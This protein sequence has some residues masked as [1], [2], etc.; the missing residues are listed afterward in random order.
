[1]YKLPQAATNVLIVVIIQSSSLVGDER[2]QLTNVNR[3]Y[4][5][6][7]FWREIFFFRQIWQRGDLV[8]SRPQINATLDVLTHGG[9]IAGKRILTHPETRRTA[10]EE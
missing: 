5:I 4:D 10:S 1:M 9:E 7:P 3:L 6:Q 8:I 2:T